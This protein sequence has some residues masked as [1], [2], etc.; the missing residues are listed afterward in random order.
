MGGVVAFFEVSSVFRHQRNH[1]VGKLDLILDIFEGE[2]AEV[3]TIDQ[4]QT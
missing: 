4:E 1:P 3:H 2:A